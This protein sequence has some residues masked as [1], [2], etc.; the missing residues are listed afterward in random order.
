[1]CASWSSSSRNS[2]GNQKTPARSNRSFSNTSNADR[3]SCH[4]SCVICSEQYKAA[5][6]IYAGTCGHV[7]HWTCLQRW[8]E[9][10]KQCPIC[11][12]TNADYFQIYLDFEE[13]TPSSQNQSRS[14]ENVTGIGGCANQHENLLYEAELYRKEIE[15]LNARIRHLKM[16]SL[17]ERFSCIFDDSD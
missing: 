13:T 17:C 5:D 16:N 10:S 2:G 3:I 6:N 11:R 8:W 15:Y 14:H 9:E 12:S 7:F 4:V 1:M